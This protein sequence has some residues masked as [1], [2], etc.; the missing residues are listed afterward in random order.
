MSSR[1]ASLGSVWSALWS[2]SRHEVAWAC[3]FVTLVLPFALVG[4]E[5]SVGMTW[6]VFAC[7]GV[8][9]AYG[10]WAT[11]ALSRLWKGDI[12]SVIDPGFGTV[13]TTLHVCLAVVLGCLV[14][15][16]IFPGIVG[17]VL[18]VGI[19]CVALWLLGFGR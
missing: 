19:V 16:V 12:A 18:G 5:P 4:V 6:F 15:W 1:I 10:A 9:V 8:S 14:A 17:A 13:M 11:V 7:V 2:V 3:V